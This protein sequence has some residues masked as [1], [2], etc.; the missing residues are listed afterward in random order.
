MT[1]R[2]I[3]DAL[4]VRYSEP[5]YAFLEHVPSTT[6][7]AATRTIDGVAMG[8]WPSRGLDLHGFEVKVSRGDW[9]REL[10]KPEKAD[11]WRFDYFWIVAPVD[12]VKLSELPKL[13]GLLEL[14]AN[15]KLYVT[16]EAVDMKPKD[17]TRPMLAAMMRKVHKAVTTSDDIARARRAGFEDGAASVARDTRDVDTARKELDGLRKRIA[18]FETASGVLIDGYSDMKALGKLVRAVKYQGPAAVRQQ[19]QHT[20]DSVARVAT[21]INNVLAELGQ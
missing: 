15:G 13:W 7:F 17:V 6:G 3:L 20:A 19:L 5:A 8:L 2:T 21:S 16:K 10:K 9:L 18:D 14:K 4:A 12:V 11:G 1:E